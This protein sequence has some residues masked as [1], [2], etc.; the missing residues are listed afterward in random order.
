MIVD[1]EDDITCSV[2]VQMQNDR[3][4]KFAM[5]DRD[6]CEFSLVLAG[7]HKL[8]TG[9]TNYLVNICNLNSLLIHLHVF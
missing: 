1:R 5:E 4:I 9:N 3:I 2:H 7:Y 8:L 6:A